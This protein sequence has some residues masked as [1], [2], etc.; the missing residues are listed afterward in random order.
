MSGSVSVSRSRASE[1]CATIGEERGAEEW[2]GKQA[3]GRIRSGWPGGWACHQGGRAGVSR[4]AR[5]AMTTVRRGTG[6]GARRR[7]PAATTA[8]HTVEL[9]RLG[10]GSARRM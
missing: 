3:S 4:R 5:E 7:R 2:A 9:A 1:K 10:W 8:E 6:E